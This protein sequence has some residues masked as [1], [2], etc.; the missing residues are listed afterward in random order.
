MFEYILSVY[1]D[2]IIGA[3]LVAAFGTLGWFFGQIWRDHINDDTKRAIAKSV[4]LFVEQ[5]WI[6]LH[7]KEK[8]KKALGVAELLLKK[9]GIQFDADEMTVL[10]E[11]AV[12]EFNEAF[13]KPLEDA[14]SA[15]AVHW[16]SED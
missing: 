6:S 15:E 10:I 11:A 1:G 16:P 7:G 13:K 14:G 3:L 4:V 2:K 9:K 12:A 5:V 8:L